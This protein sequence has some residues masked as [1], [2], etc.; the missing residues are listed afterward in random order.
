M[1]SW[2]GKA[3][4][5]YMHKRN[6]SMVDYLLLHLAKGVA[7]MFGKDACDARFSYFM[8]LFLCLLSHLIHSC[9]LM[10][11]FLFPCFRLWSFN[12]FVW[13]VSETSSYMLNDKFFLRKFKVSY[14]TLVL[15]SVYWRKT[16]NLPSTDQI[17]VID[18][19]LIF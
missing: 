14:Q 5:T 6:E 13:I 8:Y 7:S 4:Y 1:L 16:L 15:D 9:L 11:S 10:E 18:N 17:A 19:D 12:S 2:N 3:G